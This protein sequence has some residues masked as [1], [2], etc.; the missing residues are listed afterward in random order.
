MIRPHLLSFY[1][2]VNFL[3]WSWC[4]KDVRTFILRVSSIKTHPACLWS[5][6]T[7]S[8]SDWYAFYWHHCGPMRS[9]NNLPKLGLFF[10]HLIDRFK[11]KNTYA[12]SERHKLWFRVPA[13]SWLILITQQTV[14]HV[15][16]ITCTILCRFFGTYE[17]DH[18]L[19]SLPLHQDKNLMCWTA[20]E[21]NTYTH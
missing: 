14:V 12:M 10:T 2:A 13:M 17:I 20:G 3:G 6:K 18:W 11:R 5:T 8:E 4:F 9:K 15:N 16:L 21:K 7:N 1:F 19:L